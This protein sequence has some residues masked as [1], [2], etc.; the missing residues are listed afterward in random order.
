MI[1]GGSLPI[2]WRELFALY[3]AFSRDEPSPLPTPALQY[4]DYTIWERGELASDEM[5][6]D[7]AYWRQQLEGA[8]R[9]ALPIDRHTPPVRELAAHRHT[10]AIAGPDAQ[11]V[12]EAARRQGATLVMLLLAALK[13]VLLRRTGQEDIVVAMPSFNRSRRPELPG[14]IG[15]FTNN[16]ALRTQLR[17]GWTF[18]QALDR[19]RKV[20]LS[21]YDHADLPCQLAWGSEAALDS[22]LMRV[23][24]NLVTFGRQGVGPRQAGPLTLEPVPLRP[25]PLR[26][27][28]VL[29]QVIDTPA[30]LFGAVLG[31]A[32]I[33]ENATVAQLAADFQTTLESAAHDPHQ[34]LAPG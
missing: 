10:V 8:P 22:D 12:R 14:M 7:R 27:F 6:A 17:P 34:R 25:R 13:T 24:L 18:A 2:F 9:V 4:P 26:R 33:F 11:A 5:K 1:D 30:G 28:D 3:Q 15:H 21:A 20:V 31:A 19:V 23:T 29:V 16:L 32:D